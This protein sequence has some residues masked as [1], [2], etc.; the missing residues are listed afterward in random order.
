MADIALA[1]SARDWPDRLH[2]H[3]LDH[4]GGRVVERVMGAEQAVACVCDALLIDDVSSFLTPRLVATMKNRSVEVIGVY[5]PEDR[6]DAKRRLLECGITDVI[7]ADAPPTEFMAKVNSTIEH[8]SPVPTVETPLSSLISIAVSGPAAG[9]GVTEVALSLAWSISRAV[10]VVLMDLDQEWPSLAQ[11]LGLPVHPNIRT[12]LDHALHQPS[13]L[14][15]ALFEVDDDFHVVGGVAD[16]GT[17]ERLSRHDAVTVIDALGATTDVIV[18]DLGPANG[19]ERGLTREFD[20]VLLVGRGD[21]VG[22]TRLIR[23]VSRVVEER[24]GQSVLVVVNG[25]DRSRYRQSEALTEI[26]REFPG[27]MVVAMPFDPRISRSAW[28]GSLGFG[29][30]YRRAVQSMAQVVVESLK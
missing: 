25:V 27:V 12:L 11:R 9:V 16:G 30:G 17:G 29:S 10:P 13:R 4:G 22:V 18:A 2:R 20:S 14:S 15:S 23:S 5:A 3:V 1:A 24:D 21:P 19:V 28:N 7:E 26:R 6:E 8:R